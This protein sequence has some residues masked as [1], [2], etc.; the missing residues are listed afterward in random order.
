M[1]RRLTPKEKVDIVRA[2]TEQLEPMI[3]LADR[4]GRTRQAIWKVIKRAGIDPSDYETF[5][6]SCSACGTPMQ[7]YRCEVRNSKHLFCS[8][9]CYYAY[10]EGRQTG[11][12]GDNRHGQRIARAVVSQYYD[13]QPDHIVHHEDRNC[14]NNHPRNLKV[15]ANQGDH[16]RYH[17]WAQ[18]GHEVKILWDGSDR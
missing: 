16:I 8:S 15:F 14:L 13:L 6:V 18:D 12:Y 4:Y 11:E 17:R 2:Y 10:I 1:T 5:T 9:S 7:R 3:N